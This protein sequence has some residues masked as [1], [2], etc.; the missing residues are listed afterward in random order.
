MDFSEIY[1]IQYYRDKG[2]DLF[3]ILDGGQGGSVWDDESRKK[4]SESCKGRRQSKESIEKIRKANL[5]RIKTPEEIENHR[6]ALEGK[7]YGIGISRPKS[8]ETIEKIKETKRLHPQIGPN[9]GQ[10]RFYRPNGTYYF[11]FENISNLKG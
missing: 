10:K 8:K 2:E 9:K 1:W 11:A 5:G 7:H 3:N 4:L 6:R